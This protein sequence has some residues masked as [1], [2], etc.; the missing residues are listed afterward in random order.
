MVSNYLII[1]KF[2]AHL[3]QLTQTAFHSEHQYVR[4]DGSLLTLPFGWDLCSISHYIVRSGALDRF[5]IIRSSLLGSSKLQ[6]HLL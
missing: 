1:L 2:K 5:T 6:L 3:S 4:L